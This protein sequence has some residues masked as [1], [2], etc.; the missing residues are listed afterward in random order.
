MSDALP[1]AIGGSKWPGTAK[2]IEELGEL[3][4]ALGKLIATGG[5]PNHWDGTN[6]V[7]RIEEEIADVTAAI[8]F[9]VGANHLSH[10]DIDARTA[11]KLDLF[12]K[13]HREQA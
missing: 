11:T 9:F 2:L 1:F 5:K 13:W 4:Q 12:L 3:Q 10:G 6:L 8:G 7:E